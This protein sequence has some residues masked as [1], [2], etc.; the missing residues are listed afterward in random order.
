M[1]AAD[2]A[3][4][5]QIA[6]HCPDLSVE[7]MEPL[8]HW[9]WGGDSDAWLVNGTRIFRFPRTPD[10]AR[11]LR[12]EV[13]LLPQLAPLL[14]LAVPAFRYVASD[15]ATQ[16]PRFVGYPA[17]PGEPMTPSLLDALA[18]P[19]AERL[20]LAA[21][22]GGFLA[23]L[24]GFPVERARE[25][26]AEEEREPDLTRALYERVRD[27]VYPLLAP[28]LRAWTDHLFGDYLANPRL[29]QFEPALIHRDL[30]SD[31]ILFDRAARRITGIIDFGDLA[32][33]DPVADFSGLAAYGTAFLEAALTAYARPLD[34]T[35]RQ[36]LAFYRRRV[37]YIA[38]AWGAERSDEQALSEGMAALRAVVRESAE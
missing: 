11:Q 10:I 23:A 1:P 27:Q 14:P 38:L 6:R 5:Q 32:F 13:C 21:Q 31:H 29:W 17:I 28:S 34:A 4:R 18:M 22:M 36:R 19:E 7:R 35:A 30:S 25:C 24:H 33:Y 16:L 15:P 20:A 26:G 37:P 2:T 12:L 8:P 9:G 3:F